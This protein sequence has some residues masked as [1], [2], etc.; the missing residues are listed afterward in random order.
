M[1]SS[2]QQK[3]SFC[4]ICTGHCGVITSVDE[5]QHLVAIHGDRDDQQTLGFICSKGTDA[6]DSH[7]SQQRILKPLKRLPDGS[8]AEISLEQALTEIAAKLRQLID[9]HG[10]NSIASYRG[11]GG[12]FSS[13]SVPLVN[14]W[15]KA[16]GSY[17]MYSNLTIDQSA[18]WVAMS[19]L[20]YWPAG[21]QPFHT[22]DVTLLIG[23]N[24]LVSVAGSGFDT[25]H[26][27]KRIKEAKAWGMKLIVIDPRKT[28]TAE[29]ADVFIQPLPGN[30]A[31]I[32][33][34]IINIIVQNNWQDQEFCDRYAA[35]FDQLKA[36]LAAYDAET[37][38]RVADIDPQLLY[39]AAKLFAHDSKRGVAGTGTGPSMSPFS[40]LAEHLVGCL[41]VV[42]GR[43]TREGE[44]IDNPGFLQ[45]RSAK[46]AQV[47]N[48]GRPWEQGPKSRIGG[49]GTVGGEMLTALL[50]DEILMAGPGQIRSLICHGGNPAA[51]VPDQ[52]KMVEALK[53]L[54]LLVSIEPFMS[55][56]AAL[57]DYI[58]PPK[59][60]YERADVHL[61]LFETAIYQHC[62]GRYTPAVADVP[63]GSELCEEWY[64]LWSLAARLDLEL[65][66]NGTILDKHHAPTSD[67][68]LSLAAS[69]APVSWEAFKA[70][71]SG[72][73]FEGEPIYAS[74][75][76]PTTASKF[77]LTPDDVLQ[78]LAALKQYCM[79]ANSKTVS[80]NH[81][82][83]SSRRG[84][85]RFNSIGHFSPYL[86][87]LMP[88]NPAYLN[89]GDMADLQLSDDD[90][91]E[92]RSDN[93]AIKVIVR[94]DA[95]VRRG[96][97][98]ISHC[99]GYLT[100]DE[101]FNQH[102]ASTNL[103]I[104]TTRDLQTINAMP[105]MSGIPVAIKAIA[106]QRPKTGAVI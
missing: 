66:C 26:P 31:A 41:N 5:N 7:N 86:K 98:S 11:S 102:G 1:P 62:Y 45:G 64:V 63:A 9:D 60:P 47:L 17:Q 35:D 87:K 78:E 61:S 56:T 2:L 36:V 39:Q 106:G 32:V 33:A 40:N 46:P 37:V 103:L 52:K 27:L 69:K 95:T 58:L 71:P 34:A 70:S 67:E 59:M 12:F 23:N 73:L 42:C 44:L 28:E 81:F 83:L 43:F 4:R 72:V 94:A 13:A 88:Y 85:H 3:K 90:W 65:E 97:V 104:S 20:G 68:V 25:R 93:G 76:D 19:R 79:N 10:A 21:T 75:A 77:K 84:R 74:A 82:I 30:D 24:P 50:A 96:V 53:S 54:E 57:S 16:I 38:A 29:F 91:I 18:K 22:N 49:F 15:M 14:S 100:D 55:A 105:R 48:I 6:V 99:F 101:D 8:F 51:S 80:P 92:V 89:P